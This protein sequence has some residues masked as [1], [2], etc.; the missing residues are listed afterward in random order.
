MGQVP[1]K[2]ETLPE[3]CILSRKGFFKSLGDED[4]LYFLLVTLEILLRFVLFNW[5]QIGGRIRLPSF[6]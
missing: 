3:G 4:Y 5:L 6:Q 2:G 1:T